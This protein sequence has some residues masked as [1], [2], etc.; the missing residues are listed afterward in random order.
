MGW[1]TSSISQK[2]LLSMM[3]KE[4]RKNGHIPEPL[5]TEIALRPGM[6]FH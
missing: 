1:A 6:F 3:T 2:T 4:C 5:L